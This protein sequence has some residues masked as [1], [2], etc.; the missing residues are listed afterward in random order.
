MLAAPAFLTSRIRWGTQRPF[1][2]LQASSLHDGRVMHQPVV[3][4]GASSIMQK[5]L[6]I[7][8][9]VTLAACGANHRPQVQTAPAPSALAAAT[10]TQTAPAPKVL[11]DPVAALIS[12]SQKHF[13]TGEREVKAGH[14]DS[15]RREFD[16][17]VEILLTS[18]YGA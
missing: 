5:T 18:P 4:G 16:A 9:C 15:A 6:G 8:L 3:R 13:E 12:V 14:L 17:A 2:P 11:V 7:G 10:P 1:R